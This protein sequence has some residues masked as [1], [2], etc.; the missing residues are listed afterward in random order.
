MRKEGRC[1]WMES[2]KHQSGGRAGKKENSFESGD[3][4][5]I[6]EVCQNIFERI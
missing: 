2:E 1:D 3:K 6:R 4:C 5:M